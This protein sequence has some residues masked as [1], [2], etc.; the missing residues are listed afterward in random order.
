MKKAR[1]TSLLFGL[2]VYSVFCALPS[3]AATPSSLVTVKLTR[4]GSRSAIACT[5]KDSSGPRFHRKQY[6]SKRPPQS[7]GRLQTGCRRKP[8]SVAKHSFPMRNPRTPGTCA[9]RRATAGRC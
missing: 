8:A 4:A 2:L 1:L 5:V 6:Q 9:C 3:D 7:P